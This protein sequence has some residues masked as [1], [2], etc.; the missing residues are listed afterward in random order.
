MT[1]GSR[2]TIGKTQRTKRG[3][4]ANVILGE[5]ALITEACAFGCCKMVLNTQN[6]PDLDALKARHRS[7]G[8]I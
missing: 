6:Q 2:R 3:F 5:D 7:L 4:G 1:R 8:L